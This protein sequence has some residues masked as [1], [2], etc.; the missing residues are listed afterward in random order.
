M[1]G[2]LV[3]CCWVVYTF[4]AAPD[5]LNQTLRE[6]LV[7]AVLVTSCPISYAG[8]YFPLAFWWIPPANAATYALIGMIVALLT[9]RKSLGLTK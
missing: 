1:V 7:Q 3:A 6:P 2:F 4:L 8:R 9:H 5:S